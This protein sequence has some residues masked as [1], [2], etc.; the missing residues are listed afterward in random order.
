MKGNTKI[1]IYSDEAISMLHN[2]TSETGFLEFREVFSKFRP[3]TE[4]GV[5]YAIFY[6]IRKI[7]NQ[8]YQIKQMSIARDKLDLKV[9]VLRRE[10]RH[11][12]RVMP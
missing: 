7:I 8:Q 12:G 6:L 10:L 11:Y 3:Q 1:G 5:E 4:S 9:S 2:T